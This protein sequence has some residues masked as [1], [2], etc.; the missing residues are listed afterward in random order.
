MVFDLYPFVPFLSEIDKK[1]I[2][3]ALEIKVK[4]T[5]P[6]RLARSRL[7]IAK[8]KKVFGHL[9]VSDVKCM[10]GEYLKTLELDS[11]PEKGERKLADDW[12]LIINELLEKD[13]KCSADAVT[14]YRI[15]ILEY[16]LERS[17]YNFEV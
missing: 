1:D 4:P 12:V 11:K 3:S 6:L 17:P 16:A 10:H 13:S 8:L 15:S 2:I 9:K 7:S 14:L 5:D